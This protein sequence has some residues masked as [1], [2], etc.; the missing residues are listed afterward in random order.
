MPR[1]LQIISRL[2]PLTYEVD[3]LRGLM[4]PATA[5]RIGL[6][7]DG[8][9]LVATFVVL[10]AIAARLYPE[11]VNDSILA[12]CAPLRS[13]GVQLPFNEPERQRCH[14]TCAV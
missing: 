12:S 14:D 10:I 2:N 3:A 9:V 4:P 11:S 8:G 5:S 13:L 1:W 7:T 6:P